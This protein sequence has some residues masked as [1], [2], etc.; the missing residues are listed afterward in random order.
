MC[1]TA[2]TTDH[3][4]NC[5]SFDTSNSSRAEQTFSNSRAC[6]WL[7]ARPQRQPVDARWQLTFWRHQTM[8]RCCDCFRRTGS[9]NPKQLTKQKQQT[10]KRKKKKKCERRKRLQRTAQRQFVTQIV[11]CTGKQIIENVIVEIALRL[12]RWLE[13]QHSKHGAYKSC[14]LVAQCATFPTNTIRPPHQ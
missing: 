1:S 12:L 11:A 13:R 10:N 6:C 7:R 8:A 4:L 9:C 5:S 2:A 14:S 3:T